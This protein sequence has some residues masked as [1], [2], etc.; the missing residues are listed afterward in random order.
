M[1]AVGD[2][3]G[4]A[5]L[6]LLNPVEGLQLYV[7]PPLAFSAVLAPEQMVAV[8]L[9]VM[10]GIGFTVTVTVVVAV[11]LPVV[12][13]TVYVVVVAGLATGFAIE[14]LL[15][16][17]AGNQLYVVAP[18]AVS[19]VLLPAQM[20]VVPVTVTVGVGTTVT[21]AVAVEEQPADVP[22]TVYVVV[23]AGDA[24]GLAMPALLS[25]VAGLQL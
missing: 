6:A 5:M 16:P 18:F 19:V 4:L 10:P 24:V 12:P 11:Q 14:A 7:V 17:V 23:A 1:V 15:S 22:V 13:E 2:A 8:P 25:P 20:V 21:V 9:A 3:V